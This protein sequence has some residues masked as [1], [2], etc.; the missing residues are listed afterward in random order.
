V[1]NLLFAG[2]LVSAD[3]VAFASVRGMPQCM[4]M[5]QACGVAAA[6]ALAQG[7]AVQ[8]IDAAVVVATLLAQGVRG[9]GGQNLADHRPQAAWYGN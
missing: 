8:E 5:G 4:A 7:C 2:R 3:P 6:Q 9:I 1:R